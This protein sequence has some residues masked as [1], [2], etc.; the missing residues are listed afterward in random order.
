MDI[1]KLTD[2]LIRHEGMKLELY[3][4]PAN[5]WTIG[6][7][8]NLEDRGITE[9][10]ARFLLSSDIEISINELQRAFNWFHLLDDTRQMAIVDLHFNLGLNR[11]KTFKKTIG[12]I[13]EAIEGRVTWSQVSDELLDSRWATQVGQRAGRIADMMRL[14]NN[15]VGDN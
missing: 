14:G 9:E 11:L 3:K 6:V 7:G 10:E 2:Q 12:L 1:Q 4:C 13:E 5:K 8:R 15:Y